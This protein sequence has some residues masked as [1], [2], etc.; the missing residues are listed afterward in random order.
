MIERRKAHTLM[1][2]YF[3]M[4]QQLKEISSKEN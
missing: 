2:K 4:E 1:D 3:R